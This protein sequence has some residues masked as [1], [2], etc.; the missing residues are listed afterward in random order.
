MGSMNETSKTQKSWY[1]R[2][3]VRALVPLSV[4]AVTG[5]AAPSVNGLPVNRVGG[6]RQLPHPASTSPL[7]RSSDRT[8]TG[9]KLQI[10]HHRR[11]L[12]VRQALED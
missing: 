3:T 10:S 8:A 4:V 1:R 12:T 7:G 5:R 9:E 6:A 11:A 2:G